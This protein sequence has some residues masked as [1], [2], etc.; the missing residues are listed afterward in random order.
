MYGEYVSLQPDFKCEIWVGYEHPYQTVQ[1]RTQYQ[2]VKGSDLSFFMTIRTLIQNANI[3][4][5]RLIFMKTE[6]NN[7]GTWGTL[8]YDFLYRNQR[9]VINTTPNFLF[10]GLIL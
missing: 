10:H 7:I 3:K 9:S 8:H 4:F 1:I 6:L 5:R 2:S